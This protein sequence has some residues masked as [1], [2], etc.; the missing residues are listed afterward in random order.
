[1]KKCDL[2]YENNGFWLW[3]A[4]TSEIITH[5]NVGNIEDEIDW[6]IVES[7]VNLLGYTLYEM[8]ENK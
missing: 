5:V 1:M 4:E 8:E 3:D 2:V 6:E 7:Q